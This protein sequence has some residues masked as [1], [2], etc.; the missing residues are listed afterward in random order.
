MSAPNEKSGPLPSFHSGTIIAA[1]NVRLDSEPSPKPP[2]DWLRFVL[3]Q[4]EPWPGFQLSTPVYLRSSAVPA[5]A[6]IALVYAHE[7]A[8]LDRVV[9]H[10]PLDTREALRF[11]LDAD[12]QDEAMGAAADDRQGE[13]R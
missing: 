11:A 8:A 5:L 6:G 4:R 3:L 13:A 7:R 1:N 9:A 2:T 10:L 12:E